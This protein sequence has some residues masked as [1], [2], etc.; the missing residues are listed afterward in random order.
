MFLLDEGFNHSDLLLLE[1]RS[2]EFNRFEL[3]QFSTR[4]FHKALEVDEH[5]SGASS[6]RKVFEHID[7]LLVTDECSRRSTGDASGASVVLCLHELL[8]LSLENIISTG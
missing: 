8:E 3:V 2:A 5:R 1:D 4:G 6:R 7:G